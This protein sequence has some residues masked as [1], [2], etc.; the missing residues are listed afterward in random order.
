[1]PRGGARKGAGRPHGVTTVWTPEQ[2]DR[3]RARIQTDQIIQRLNAVATGEIT[4]EDKSF[5]ASITAALGL[6]KKV[7]PDTTQ[8]E[9]KGEIAHYVARVPNV[10]ET[11]DQWQEQHTPERTIQ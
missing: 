11:A 8:V 9:H 5:S 7:V 3:F 1:M 6:L 10:A 4:S 2:V